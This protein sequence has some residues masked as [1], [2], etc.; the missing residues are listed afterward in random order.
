[1]SASSHKDILI[2]ATGWNHEAWVGSY[3]PENLPEDWRLSFYSNEFTT[4]LVPE[5]D[6]INIQKED[7]EQWIND[8]HDEFIFFF[9]ANLT[10]NTAIDQIQRAANLLE[11]QNKDR[12]QVGAL[13]ITVPP[14]TSEADLLNINSKLPPNLSVSFDFIKSKLSDTKLEDILSSLSLNT[15]WHSDL[16][17]KHTP[18]N[19]LQL[20]IL[21]TKTEHSNKQLKNYFEQFRSITNNSSQV[22][23]F[24]SGHPPDINNLYNIKMIKE[25]IIG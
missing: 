25:L 5:C 23:L 10:T 6:W 4:V 16:S 2:G 22:A 21:D 3:Y 15:T 9:E 18:N 24:L 19:G 7:I 8:T 1:M 14:E 20:G 13:L 12:S 11:S 17:Y